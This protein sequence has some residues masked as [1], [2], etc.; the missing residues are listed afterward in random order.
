MIVVGIDPGIARVGY[1]VI[2]G[3][4]MRACG[5]IET[6]KSEEHSRR[7]AEIYGR[8]SEILDEHAPDWMAV[9]QLF[10]TRNKSSAMQV[11][12]VRGV[13]L[14]AAEQRG[15]PIAEYTPNQIKLA[16][17]GSGKAEKRQVQEM[18]RRLLG[19]DGIPRPDDAA[20]GLAVALCHANTR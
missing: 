5:C 15:I 3:G 20:D 6:E 17:T 2:E 13:I 19:L 10:F 18:M 14:L 9:E 7:L 8:V 11:G 4:K 12:E 16:V 1:G